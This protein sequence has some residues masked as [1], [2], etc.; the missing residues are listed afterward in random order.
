MERPSACFFLKMNVETP[1]LRLKYC[2]T[3]DESLGKSQWCVK[4]E[5]LSTILHKTKAT[6]PPSKKNMDGVL[7]TIFC[8]P[9]SKVSVAWLADEILSLKRHRISSSTLSWLD[10]T[11]FCDTLLVSMAK[12]S[13]KFIY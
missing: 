1:S 6:K 8:F 3:K 10:A 12:F 2:K 13:T 7:P 4:T 5:P 11:R 9:L